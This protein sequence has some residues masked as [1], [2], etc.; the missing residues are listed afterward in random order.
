MG[1]GGEG[2]A[3][4]ERK[5]PGGRRSGR[6]G[7]SPGEPGRPPGRRESSPAPS[8]RSFSPSGRSFPPSV[9]A[10]APSVRVSAP[11]GRSFSPS[12]GALEASGSSPRASGRAPGASG[13]PSDA[14]GRRDRTR[15]D[16]SQRISSPPGRTL[17]RGG[18]E[19]RASATESRTYGRLERPLERPICG[20]ARASGGCVRTR[21][22]CVR[23]RTLRVRWANVTRPDAVPQKK[24]G[25][26]VE[27][28]GA[29]LPRRF[30]LSY[31]PCPLP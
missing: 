8:G 23:T 11:S 18:R 24:S 5:D 13:S 7:C 4:D 12:G 14:S 3:R 30:G 20:P 19:D 28:L 1:G 15:P 16:A 10:S 6:L 9:P 25:R 17:W 2:D 31:A 27:E 21:P 22:M 26:A 29:L